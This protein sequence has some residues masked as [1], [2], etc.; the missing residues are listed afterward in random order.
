MTPETLLSLADRV[1]AGDGPDRELD[2]LVFQAV[3]DGVLMR[4]P[5]LG[6][7][8]RAKNFGPWSVM[9]ALTSSLDAV[10]ALRVRM[11]P[12]SRLRTMQ[13]SYGGEWYVDITFADPANQNVFGAH[14]LSEPRARLAAIL[15]ALAQGGV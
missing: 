7:E 12:G 10:E 11:L 4:G 3:G 6:W 13:M 1:C 14:S 9:P 8:W 15:R 5:K 2:A